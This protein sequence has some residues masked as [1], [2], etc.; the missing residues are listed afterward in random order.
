M[1][2]IATQ[3]EKLLEG[4]MFQIDESDGSLLTNAIA[5]GNVVLLLGAGTSATSRNAQGENV[6][7]GRSLAR[8]LAEMAGYTYN[9][10]PLPSVIQAIEPRVSRVQ[11]H[12]IFKKEYTRV[13]P[14]SELNSLFQYTWRRIYTWNIDDAIENVRSSEQV[15]HYYNGMIDHVAADQGLEYLHV[16]HLH[17]EAS[18]PEHGH[19]FGP[20]EYNRRLNQDRHDWYRQAAIDYATHVPVFIGSTLEE[21]ILLAELDRAR[22][23]ESASLGVAFLITPDEMTDIQKAGYKARNISVINATLEDFTDWLKGSIGAG[24]SPLQISR[25]KSA[26]TD[27]MAMRITPTKAEVTTANSI[28]LH[29]WHDAKSR[30][31]ELTGL[32]KQK[33]ARAFL[34]GGPPSWKLAASDVPVWLHAT[35]DMYSALSESIEASDRM[36]LVYGQS[37]SG[38]TTALMQ[39]LLRYARENNNTPVYELK[40][41]VKSLRASLELIAR[42]NE[43]EQV[44]VFIGDAFLYG[45]ALGE[46]ALSFKRGAMT[47]V[48]SARSSEWRSHIERRVGD[49]AVSFE[50]QRFVSEDHHPLIKRLL[51]YVPSPRFRQM[52]EQQ[53][54]ARLASSQEQ[55]LIA[56]KES[57]SSEKF[58]KVITDE[59]EK[60]SELDAKLLLLIVGLTTLA[61]TGISEGSAR[62]AYNKLRSKLS[63]DGAL[64]HLDGIVSLNISGRLVARHELYVRHIIENVADFDI[65]V[66]SAVEILRT[67]TKYP[68]PIVRNVPRLDSLL[69]KF[70]LNHNFFGELARRRNEVEEGLR[71]FQSFEVDFQLDGHFWLQY[72]QYQVMFGEL[73]PAL[74]SLRKSIEAYPENVFAVHA[75]ADLQL[76]V[77]FARPV[78]D[79]ETISLIGD[80]V[81]TLERLH[82]ANSGDDDFYPI[83]T[84]S[85]WHVPTLVQHGQTK[86]AIAAAKRYFR[87]IGEMKRTDIPVERSRERLA[88]FVTHG[89][90]D[91]NTGSQKAGG[92]NGA[93]KR[94]SK[95]KRGRRR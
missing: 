75:L 74:D 71:L 30:A 84:L 91:E 6:K 44:I 85:D 33:A 18:K 17:G 24:L 57:T 67:F 82:A 72:A 13:I 60:L 4:Q 7:L 21:P 26:F 93:S 48:T 90:W 22:P 1:K 37:G 92:N 36:F 80:A 88:H 65:I 56:L 52:T 25:S 77:A 47:L 3:G 19:I 14:S 29:T 40:G 64:R 87:M 86:P 61:R 49:F 63:F 35:G 70:I 89:V 79:A 8:H 41:D 32:S 2:I 83:A 12:D 94:G 81:G 51:E 31:D 16:V 5:D 54:V 53:R 10:E 62:E 20:S 23:S 9:L 59:F 43:G 78:Y 46:D 11:L 69:F 45:D 58:T 42:L 39:C 38:K 55:L 66:D 73:E 34:E 50:F 76:R 95:G 28:I 27:S 15:R 68:V